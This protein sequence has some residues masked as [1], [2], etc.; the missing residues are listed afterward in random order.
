MERN[1]ALEGRQPR[2]CRVLI[3]RL[4][5][6]TWVTHP[7]SDPYPF[8]NCLLLY[9]SIQ[10]MHRRGTMNRYGELRTPREGEFPVWK[11]S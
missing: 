2:D 9:D 3:R 7:T 4:R 11:N 6:L 8:I 5:S 1:S 10:G